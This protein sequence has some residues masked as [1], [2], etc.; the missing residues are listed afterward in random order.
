M[1]GE[2]ETPSQ[3]TA[4]R[5]QGRVVFLIWMAGR[6]LHWPRGVAPAQT[7]LGTLV[8][9]PSARRTCGPIQR[10][11]F[12]RYSA[13]VVCRALPVLQCKYVPRYFTPTTPSFSFPTTSHTIHHFFL[14][15]LG[16]PTQPTSMLHACVR[17]GMAHYDVPRVEY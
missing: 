3:D 16:H 13:S 10:R 15:P 2:I 11:S 12:A 14:L 6:K 9:P 7:I 1:T 5:G 4:G 8:H 17:T